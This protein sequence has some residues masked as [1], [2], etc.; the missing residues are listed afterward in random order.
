MPI[1]KIGSIAKEYG[2]L[3]LVDASQGAGTLDII[4]EI[5]FTVKA[6]QEI[7]TENYQKKKLA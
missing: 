1:T 4:E 2:I 3:F 6:L 5:D 7:V